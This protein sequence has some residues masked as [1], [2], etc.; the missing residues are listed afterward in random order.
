MIMVESVRK[1]ALR[2]LFFRLNFGHE[3]FEFE[4]LIKMNFF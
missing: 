4:N 3:S 1:T 2:D